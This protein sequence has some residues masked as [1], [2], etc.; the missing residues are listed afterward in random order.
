MSVVLFTEGIIGELPKYIEQAKEV[1]ATG[2]HFMKVQADSP[3]FIMPDY[4]KHQD[5]IRSFKEMGKKAGLI[6]VGSSTDKPT[7]RRCYYP[8][9]FPF[10]LLNNDVYACNYMANLRRTEVYMNEVFKVPYQEYRMGN[11]NNNTLREI[12]NNELYKELRQALR[13]KPN[14][15]MESDDFLLFMKRKLSRGEI[16]PE[17]KDLRFSFCVGCLCQWG[18]SGL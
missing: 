8:F 3:D 9:F 2:I 1:K 10:I 12:W 17:F 13:V 16:P 11:L 5:L 6:M 7:F 18:E 4:S 14:R 15:A